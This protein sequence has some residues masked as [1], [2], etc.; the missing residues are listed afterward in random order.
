MLDVDIKFEAKRVRGVY[1][2]PWSR[3]SDIPVSREVLEKLGACLVR[4]V[5]EE[6]KKDFAKRGWSMNDPMGGPPIHQSFSYYIRGKSTVE[7]RSTFYGMSELGKG[8]IPKRRMTWLTQ[9]AKEKHPER[10]AL[11]RRER[12]L[13]MRPAGRPS[14]GTRLPLVVP[15]QSHGGAVVFRMAPLTTREA[16]VHPGIAKFTFIQRGIRKGRLACIEILKKELAKHMTQG[17]PTR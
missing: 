1:G 7:V 4:T 9:E 15:I 8:R 6:A 13:G 14:R 12:R 10:Y 16:W 17:D 5:V 2:K 3:L 11:T